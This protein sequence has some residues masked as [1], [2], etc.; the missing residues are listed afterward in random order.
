MAP[1]GMKG[2]ERQFLVG[3]AK[4]DKRHGESNGVLTSM[5]DG[6]LTPKVN[7]WEKW[8]QQPLIRAKKKEVADIEKQAA[9]LALGMSAAKKTMAAA[10]QD[11]RKTT[12]GPRQEAAEEL[13][14]EKVNERACT[15]FSRTTAH[16]H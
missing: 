1:K 12:E 7:A 9:K 10:Q 15:M 14:A 6:W 8:L 13:V 11:A 4:L 3:C 16:T 5:Y 2:D